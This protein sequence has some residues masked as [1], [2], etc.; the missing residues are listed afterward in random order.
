MVGNESQGEDEDIGL[1]K[2]DRDEDKSDG[3]DKDEGED[4]G[5][6]ITEPQKSVSVFSSSAMAANRAVR[7]HNNAVLYR[8]VVLN[9]LFYSLLSA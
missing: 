6:Y 3:D 4:K 1:D 8:P 7:W 5:R 9:S 2:T